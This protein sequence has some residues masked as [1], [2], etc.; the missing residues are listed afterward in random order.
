[1]LGISTKIMATMD[2]TIK[3]EW[4]MDAGRDGLDSD[5]TNPLSRSLARLINTGKPFSRLSLSFLNE[6]QGHLRWFGVFVESKRTLFFP[7]FSK[8]FDGIESHRG[9]EPHARRSFEFDHLSL[10]KDRTTWHVTARGSSDHLGSP[11]TLALGNGRVLWFGLSFASVDAFRPVQNKT[12]TEFSTPPS[13]ASR[14]RDIITASRE[15][16]KFSI[17]SLPDGPLATLP[18]TY[19]H[20]SVIAGPAGFETCLGP[21]HAFPIG[22]PF[23]AS[24]FPSVPSDLPIRI[25]RI[26]LSPDTDLQITLTRLSGKLTVPVAFTGPEAPTETPVGNV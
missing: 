24:P 7:G 18:E 15:R 23:L 8:A 20:A 1:M 10:E 17:L 14:R 4:S 13:D 3:I 6:G 22:S 21:E 12:V 11:R 2:D 5:P 26:Q 25:H 19:F 9:P 16:A